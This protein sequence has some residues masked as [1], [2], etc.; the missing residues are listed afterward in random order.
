VD[1]SLVGLLLIRS[2]SLYFKISGVVVGAAALAPLAFACI[3]YLTRGGFENGEDLLNRAAPAPEIDLTANLQ[4][5]LLK[6]NQAVT[7]P[8]LPA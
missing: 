6:S 2:N 7:M 4:L 3:S 1:A 8:S 5:Q